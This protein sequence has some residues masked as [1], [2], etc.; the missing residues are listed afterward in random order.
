LA[1]YEGTLLLVS[2]DRDFLDNTVTKVL[3][4]EGEGVIEGYM[5]GYTDYLEQKAQK[6]GQKPTA[7]AQAKIQATAPAPV[8]FEKKPDPLPFALKKELEQL[9]KTMAKLEKTI[10]KL[11]EDLALPDLYTTDPARFDDLAHQLQKAEN[12]LSTAETRWLELEEKRG[13]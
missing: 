3:A 11:H 7:K 8:T 5:G 9:P 12:D 10:E 1:N 6:T 2:H 4:F 13:I